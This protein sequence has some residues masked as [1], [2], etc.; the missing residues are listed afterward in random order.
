MKKNY[1]LQ[2]PCSVI[3]YFKVTITQT[4]QMGKSDC[5]HNSCHTV[6]EKNN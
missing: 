5:N 1:E 3:W 2:L 6:L 4:G